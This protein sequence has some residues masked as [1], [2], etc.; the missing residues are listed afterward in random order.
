MWFRITSIPLRNHCHHVGHDASMLAMMYQCW[1]WCLHVGHDALMLAMIPQCWPWCFNVGRDTSMLAV[2]LECWPWYLNVG[3]DAWMVAT[4]PP[5][6]PWCL[7]AN[8][9]ST[10]FPPWSTY[11]IVASSS[12]T[13]IIDVSICYQW[14][15]ISS[16]IA[17]MDVGN[18]SIDHVCH[19][20]QLY[21]CIIS[22]LYISKLLT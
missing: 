5:C 15:P 17:I 16:I 2:M 21:Y 10:L 7:N 4:M 22:L 14:T 3:R 19:Q 6:W 20:I 11:V 9:V 8:V 18:R 1:P 13:S 12:A